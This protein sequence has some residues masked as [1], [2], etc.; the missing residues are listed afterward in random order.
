MLALVSHGC[1]LQFQIASLGILDFQY[2]WALRLVPNPLHP[3]SCVSPLGVMMHEP[4]TIPCSAVGPEVISWEAE[5]T[6]IK[7]EV[8]HRNLSHHGKGLESVT[9]G[10]AQ[11]LLCLSF[12][13]QGATDMCQLLSL[14]ALPCFCSWCEWGILPSTSL[15]LFEG[16]LALSALPSL[17]Q[18]YSPWFSS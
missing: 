1:V 15:A 17:A 12:S 13:C 11:S 10:W 9:L 8:Y 3:T 5:L 7:K 18:K 4:L 14:F 2:C 6:L 16:R